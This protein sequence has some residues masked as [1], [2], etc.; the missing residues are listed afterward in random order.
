MEIAWSQRVMSLS[1]LFNLLVP[2]EGRQPAADMVTQLPGFIAPSC[3]FDSS[4]RTIAQGRGAVRVLAC[5]NLHTARL[6]LES[7]LEFLDQVFGSSLEYLF[8]GGS[9]FVE[10][11][12][13]PDSHG[14]GS[15]P[16]LPGLRLIEA[17]FIER[18]AVGRAC[19]R[20]PQGVDV[21]DLCTAHGI[22]SLRH[23]AT[24]DPGDLLDWHT[25]VESAVRAAVAARDPTRWTPLHEAAADAKEERAACV[26]ALLEMGSDV[27]LRDCRGATA[28]WRASWAG[29]ARIVQMLL[30]AGA[31]ALTTNHALERPLYIAA[32]RGHVEC[33]TVLAEH[34]A[35]IEDETG[36]GSV[37]LNCAYH[38]G[39]SPLHAAAIGKIPAILDLM[40]TFRFE[41]RAPNR[42]KQTPLHIAAR[43]GFEEGLLT[44]AQHGGRAALKDQDERGISVL[45]V[46]AAYCPAVLDS[47]CRDLGLISAGERAALLRPERPPLRQ[48]SGRSRGPR[49]KRAQ[50]AGDPLANEWGHALWSSLPGGQGGGGER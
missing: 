29:N 4:E 14:A 45:Q 16:L 32:L 20:L 31:D 50:R 25:A 17:T 5:T 38:D 39:W 48:P 35:A 6:S 24:A 27:K 41:P 13:D 28:L 34:L 1:G 44:L 2:S 9:S 26:E 8:L 30:A 11:D 36:G 3:V 46:A 49:A 42:Y 33:V 15:R 21:I 10:V 43:L 23:A 40:L 19:L 18:S 37:L 22:R 7:F 12:L 47:L